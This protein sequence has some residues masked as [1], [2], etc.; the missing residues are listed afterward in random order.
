MRRIIN[1]TAATVIAAVAFVATT[2][3]ALA[4]VIWDL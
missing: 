4:E 3:P 2:A 1:T